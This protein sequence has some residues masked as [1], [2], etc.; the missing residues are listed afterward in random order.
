MTSGPP[1][2]LEGEGS[3]EPLAAHSE[4]GS[5]RVASALGLPDAGRVLRDF[6][7]Y[8]PTQIVPAV[9][10]FL[11]LPI[12]ARR[13]APTELGVLAI[14]QTLASL[15]WILT[16]Q[17]LTSAAMRE[18]PGARAAGVLGSVSRTLAR[19]LGVTAVLFSCFVGL[20][21]LLGVFS[22]AIGGNVL[23][24]AAVA[25]GLVIQNVAGTLYT[26]TL[27]TGAYAALELVGRTGGIALG[28]YFVFHGHK[29][30]GYL[31]G[32]A[33]VSVIAGLIGLA[34]AWPRRSA[35]VEHAA[36]T[37]VR[38]WL[39]YGAPVA[40][41]AAAVWGLM[42][43]DRYLLA[44]LSNTGEVGLYSLG[45]VIGDKAVAIPILAFYTAA[46]PLLMTAYEVHGREEME[47]LMRAYT[48]VILLIGIPILAY[49]SVT[50]R[51]LISVL[52]AGDYRN[53]YRDAASVIP[54]VAAGSLI[55][56]LAL[57]GSTGLT[58]SRRTRQL[59][60]GSLIG[61]G[62]NVVANLIL[63]PPYGA[64]GA[65]I[66]TPIGTAAFLF[67]TRIWA[68]R[69][70]TWHFPYGTLS[71]AAAAGALGVGAAL[72]VMQPLDS[73]V[74]RLVLTAAAGGIVYVLALWL[75]GERRGGESVT[76]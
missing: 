37:S 54:F 63:I 43:V 56:L 24:I 22:G 19:G 46:R 9:A 58:V 57:I 73:D 60:Y 25:G 26:A 32:V 59:V 51:Q 3:S 38:A 18:L 11:A 66:S 34:F 6:L 7:T 65:A 53:F 48:R 49:V 17:W 2:V 14:A 72:A 13:L 74:A 29:L 67:S 1:A 50:D 70:A 68:R 35:R 47:R 55:Y 71:R 10:G 76:A 69:H 42:F 62:A 23:L 75:F 12:L 27:R 16:S 4:P 44:A 45:A 5:L 40:V 20:V 41:S 15:G 39:S 61:L 36:A 28:I 64:L 30:Q 8:L 33:S 31:L 21:A 52:A